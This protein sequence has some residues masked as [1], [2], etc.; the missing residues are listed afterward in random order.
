MR[1]IEE[2]GGGMSLIFGAVN[3]E[4]LKRPEAD[5]VFTC[6]E[7]TQIR[8]LVALA[9][10][11]SERVHMPVHVTATVP[12]LFGEEPV[13]KFQLALSLKQKGSS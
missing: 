1:A 11:S 4:F 9:R 13:A 2:S 7:G 12:S 10:S 5:V 8:E 6:L 3:A